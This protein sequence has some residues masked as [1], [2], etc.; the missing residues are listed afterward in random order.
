[1]L[2]GGDNIATVTLAGTEAIIENESDAD[3]SIIVSA[4][5]SDASQGDVVITANTGA[6]LTLTDGWEYAV[7]GA[8]DQVIPASGQ[9]GTSVVINGTSLQGQ[10]GEVV[11]VTLAGTEVTIESE[12]DAE[13][14]V[15]VV[16]AEAGSGD[17]VLLADTGAI[18]T[19]ED[20]WEYLS[21][22]EVAEADPS[23]GQTGTLVTI[24][25]SRLRGGG[26]E[27]TKVTLVG[28]EAK[29]VSE[30]DDEVIVEVNKGPEQ[31]VAGD[32]VLTSDSGAIVTGSDSFEYVN[33]P[34]ILSVDP[35][36]GRD[37]STV[38]IVGSLCGGGSDIINVTLIGIE[39]TLEETT[40]TEVRITAGD[41]GS[42]AVGD[43][44][45]TAD[46]GARVTLEDGWTYL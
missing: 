10:G 8:I 21:I 14:E 42:N 40:C 29:I 7:P 25:G 34:V 15:T 46:T 2:G 23:N 17:V 38:K 30:T 9:L 27:V 37:G 43:V 1:M 26:D 45:I 20:A 11:K 33:A 35:D 13:I 32:I 5:Q 44:L 19:S 16:H 6:Q 31:K 41:Y 24:S 12:S 36:E 22:G 4:A 39:A 28:V 3:S 18:I